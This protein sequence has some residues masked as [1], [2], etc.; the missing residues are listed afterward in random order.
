MH[1]QVCVHSLFESSDLSAKT[2]PCS[3]LGLT[4]SRTKNRKGDRLPG[5]E[6][7]HTPGDL[8]VSTAIGP[9]LSA[10]RSPLGRI[11]VFS[12]APRLEARRISMARA[13][14]ES[15]HKKSETH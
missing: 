1:A 10:S 9:R 7:C 5:R 3:Q 4:F 15:G 11:G 2:L 6:W 8:V 14:P 13:P 12:R